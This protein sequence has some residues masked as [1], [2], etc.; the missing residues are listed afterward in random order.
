MIHDEYTDEELNQK[1]L[2][3]HMEGFEPPRKAYTITPRS[4]GKYRDAN[5]M[6]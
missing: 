4:Y 3:R 1:S 2:D 6:P 5:H